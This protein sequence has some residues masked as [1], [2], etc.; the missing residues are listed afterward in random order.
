MPEPEPPPEPFGPFDDDWVRAA[1]RREET[2]EERAERY[3]RIHVGHVRAQ[4]QPGWRTAPPPGSPPSGETKGLSLARWF[5]TI[6]GIVLAVLLVV[7]LVGLGRPLLD[8]GPT[9]YLGEDTP[10]Q[11]P[12]AGSARLDPANIPPPGADAAPDRIVPAM[13]PPI[14]AGDYAFLAE[15]N[16]APITYS[17]CRRLE[18]VVNT[19][20]A[21]PGAYQAVEEAV[22]Q[23]GAAAGLSLTVAGET[24]E[25]YRRNRDP[26]Q[27]ERY[28][29]TWAPILVSWASRETV[30]EFA[31]AAVGLG[32]SLS[33]DPRRGGP[34]YVTG[35]VTLNREYF[36]VSTTAGLLREVLLHELGHVLGLDHVPDEGQVMTSEAR[37]GRPLGSGDLAGL[38]LLGQ[39][40]CTPNL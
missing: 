36:S 1:K 18:V 2:A 15:R 16:G 7:W 30:P 9:A 20:G 29:E 35:E 5:F 37:G 14:D 19:T 40:R 25:E 26:Y 34:S 28:G 31:G 17:P 12:G 33:V 38:A 13:Q 3:R 8:D 27:P 22:S 11:G 6:V 24:D 23:V 10:R 32:G 39:G 21:P 4:E